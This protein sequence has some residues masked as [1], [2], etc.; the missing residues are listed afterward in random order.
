MACQ[1]Q[2]RAAM[3]AL[4]RQA[5]LRIL[6]RWGM[7]CACPHSSSPL[8][9]AKLIGPGWQCGPCTAGEIVFTSC[10][11]ESDSWAI[12]GIVTGPAGRAVRSRAG[13]LPHVVS[14]QGA[15]LCRLMQTVCGSVFC[16]NRGLGLSSPGISAHQAWS[17]EPLLSSAELPPCAAHHRQQP[18]FR[19]VSAV[20]LSTQ[21]S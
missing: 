1:R 11:T 4:S 2:Q 10:G 8:L 6:S 19:D 20:R 13:Q 21:P 18:L 3:C 16:H 5:C 17:A 9:E 15:L 14:R 12:W 7:Q